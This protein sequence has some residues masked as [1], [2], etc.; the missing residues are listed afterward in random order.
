VYREHGPRVRAEG[1]LPAATRAGPR[2]RPWQVVEK[3][4][5]CTFSTRSRP[6]HAR[7]R[8]RGSIAYAIDPRAI[9]PWIALAGC[10]S[11]PC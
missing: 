6:V 4:L 1:N 2:G 10:F 7:T 3:V 8:L 5:S 9:H 11:T